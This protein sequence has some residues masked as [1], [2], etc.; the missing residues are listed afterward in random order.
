MN[1]DLDALLRA[2]LRPVDPGTE[3]TRQVL[4]AVEQ[5]AERPPSGLRFYGRHSAWRWAS[6][7]LTVT[8]VIG[9]VTVHRHRAQGLE[10]RQQ[11]IQAL[12]VTSEKLDVA[13][14]VVNEQQ[15]R[16]DGS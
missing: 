10:A 9:L 7:A 5:D 4:A 3:L 8:L 15:N 12:R 14:R 16:E 11:L 2:A 1:D 13:Y 6:V